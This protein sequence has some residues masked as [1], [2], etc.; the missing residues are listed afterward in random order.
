MESLGLLMGQLA[1]DGYLRWV[2]LSL[3]KNP[4]MFV[5][6]VLALSLALFAHWQRS[7]EEAEWEGDEVDST[8]VERRTK[9]EQAEAKDLQR[10][11]SELN[12]QRYEKG[13][14]A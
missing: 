14:H 7:V 4:P 10:K 11:H 1:A 9:N 2:P 13:K 12:G 3:V 8:E 5:V 6:P